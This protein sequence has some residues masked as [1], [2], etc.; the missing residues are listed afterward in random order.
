M[1]IKCIYCN[2][3]LS[4]SQYP[5]FSK[6][7]E[8][9]QIELIDIL[10]AAHSVNEITF[11]SDSKSIWI[12]LYPEL[13]KDHP[14]LVGAV[15]NRAEAQV[16]RLA[17]IFALLDCSNII[18]PDH[19]YAAIATWRYCEDSAKLIFSDHEPDSYANKILESLK[20]GPKTKSDFHSL[21]NRKL[22]A[23]KLNRI[24]KELTAQEKIKYTIENTNT[25]SKNLYYL[26]ASET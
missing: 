24:L 23:K 8:G 10:R 15:I 3:N 7:L 22:K 16:L 9:M 13:S 26:P 19:L 14:G 5:Q 11:H 4:N 2:V 17:M 25:N 18:L 12:A 1:N 6:L 20:E 21:F